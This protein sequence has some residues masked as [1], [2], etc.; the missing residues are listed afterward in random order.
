MSVSREIK[1]YVLKGVKLTENRLKSSG[2]GENR[3]PEIYRYF[4]GE[5]AQWTDSVKI[6]SKNTFCGVSPAGG[7]W[8]FMFFSFWSLI[9]LI[10]KNTPY[11][12][13]ATALILPFAVIIAA[14]MVYKRKGVEKLFAEFKDIHTVAAVRQCRKQ[15]QKRIIFIAPWG[16]EKDRKRTT[17]SDYVFTLFAFLSFAGAAFSLIVIF[18]ASFGTVY[19]PVIYLLP[20]LI[21]F[22]TL[23]FTMWKKRISSE[24]NGA[25]SCFAVLGAVRELSEKGKRSD[26][27]DI[28]CILCENGEDGIKSA[29][30]VLK[31]NYPFE[32]ETKII[33]LDVDSSLMPKLIQ[34]DK[35]TL[36]VNRMLKPFGK[37]KSKGAIISA[38][39]F[40]GKSEFTEREEKLEAVMWLIKEAIEFYEK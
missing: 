12:G 8:L 17:F 39:D 6:F 25:E 32:G 13:A 1:D 3:E 24:R 28:Y 21:I 19:P 10:T 11:L 2:S 7:F 38:P 15:A 37:V 35:G 36:T 27:T 30:K 22:N 16:N 18:T 29:A 9:P 14:E 23:T 33:V 31:T 34:S 20:L 26:S 40:G 5:L 4:A